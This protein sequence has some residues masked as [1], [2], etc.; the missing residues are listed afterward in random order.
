MIS[1]HRCGLA[2]SR[3]AVGDHLDHPDHH[4]GVAVDLNG[5]GFLCMLP[6]ANGLHVHVDDVIP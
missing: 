5:N 2:R 6:L 4:I 3:H 1:R